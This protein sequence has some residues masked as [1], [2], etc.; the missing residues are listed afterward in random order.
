MK[1]AKLA[2]LC[3]FIS[4]M[5][6][7]SIAKVKVDPTTSMFVDDN[8]DYRIFHGV[9]VAYKEHPYYPPNLDTYNYKNS[10]CEEDAR[11]LKEWGMNVIRLTFYWEMV[12][13]QRGRYNTDYLNQLKKIM[14]I[15][16]KYDI[17]VLLDLHQDAASKK[18]CG[19][20]MPDW[21]IRE[22]TGLWKFP[23]PLVTA[24][25]QWGTDG[26]PTR[27][28]CLNNLFLTF[29]GTFAVMDAFDDLYSNWNGIGDA[30]AEMF[31]VVANH[32]KG[33]SNLLGYEIM[34][35][36]FVGNAYKNPLI[37]FWDTKMLPF[38]QKVHRKIREVDDKSIIFFEFPTSDILLNA[39]KGTPGGSGFNDRQMLSYH[40]YGVPMGDPKTLN[41]VNSR[42]EV[43][44]NHAFKFLDENKVGGFLT[45]FGAISGQSQIAVDNMKY[46]LNKADSRFHSWAYWQYKYY[47][48]YT[49]AARPSEWEGFFDDKGGVIHPKVKELARPYVTRSSA[50]LIEMKY[51]NNVLQVKFNKKNAGSNKI[52]VYLNEDYHFKG[53]LGFEGSSCS[54]CSFARHPSQ[55]RNYFVLDIAKAPANVDIL[56]QFKVQGAVK[57]QQ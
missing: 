16:N 20:G 36:P 46:I 28:S 53:T 19:E 27:A 52:E 2:L 13:A 38:Y 14:E 48:D 33:Q 56:V 30:F 39:Y 40:V 37:L 17:Q 57:A 11:K 7:A 31:K 23:N 18:Y 15:C 21:A 9:N 47:G 26:N 54:G 3:G 22:H 51:L 24:K 5:I 41:D 8:G 32:F 10:F 4:L 44:M 42:C 1:V 35:E 12:E 49:T 43:I 45:E 6:A 25:I 50:K 29:Y 34:N 55:P